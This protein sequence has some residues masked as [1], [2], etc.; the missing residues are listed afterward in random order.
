MFISKI[1]AEGFDDRSPW[2]D[3][4]FEPVSVRTAAG[5]RVSAD[6]ALRLGAVFACVRLLSGIMASLPFRLYRV[7]ADGGKDWITDH[8]LY[9]L[10]AKRPNRWQT[11]YEWRQM[12]AGHFELR[13][14]AYNRIVANGR[15]EVEELVPLN[16]DRVR[17]EVL[18]DGNYRYRLRGR[19]GTEEIVPRGE[20]WHLR[21]LSANG[22]MGLNPIEIARESIGVGLAMQDFSARF[23]TNDARPMG[24]WIEFPGQFKDKSARD[25]WRESWQ[26][27]Q[28]GA[29]RGKTAV[30]ENGM[31]YHEVGLSNR[32]SQFIEAQGLKIGD[33][34]RV[35]GVQPHLIGDLSRATFSNIEQQSIEFKTYTMTPRCECWES[36]IEYF[37][38]PEDDLEVEFDLANLERGDAKTR[39]LF[40]GKSILDG[41]GTR[42]EARIFENRN[43]LPGL[44]EPL[45]PLNMQQAGNEPDDAGAGDQQQR[46]NDM[47]DAAAERVVRKELAAVRKLV[48]RPDAKD[49][50][51]AFYIEHAAYLQENLRCSS[52]IA[53]TWCDERFQEIEAS[54]DLEATFASWEHGL[55]GGWHHARAAIDLAA[56]VNADVWTAGRRRRKA[57]D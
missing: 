57:G 43:P 15:G 28:A 12:L 11:P 26:T 38:S 51:R 32:D 52:A 13:G 10:L 41:W 45:E 34:A 36:S 30:L 14:N 40:H 23:F 39:A 48:Q 46:S 54:K 47:T 53:Q 55:S 3:F 42:N 31:K 50:V 19:D 44:D 16:P 2:G 8:W 35:F 25:V 29:N 27:A 7:R 22:Y 21:G 1:R 20:I 49:A 4:W 5:A 9:R 33:I 24:G 18:V 56:R 37:L 17:I 6:S